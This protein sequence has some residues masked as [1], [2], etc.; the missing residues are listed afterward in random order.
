MENDAMEG[1]HR[2]EEQV[3]RKIQ[4]TNQRVTNVGFA[5]Q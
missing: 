5:H 3:S 4:V 2:Q 1:Q